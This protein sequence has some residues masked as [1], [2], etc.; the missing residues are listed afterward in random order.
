[1][2][3][4]LERRDPEFKHKMAEVLC[5]F[6]EVKLIKKSAVDTLTDAAERQNRCD[7]RPTAERP[8]SATCPVLQGGGSERKRRRRFH[9]EGLKP[10]DATSIS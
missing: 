1:V 6:R 2:L 4:Y 10:V 9:T 5:V 3:Y 7:I 8:K